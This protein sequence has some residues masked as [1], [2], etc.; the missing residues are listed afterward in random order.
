MATMG[1]EHVAASAPNHATLVGLDGGSAKRTP[2]GGA[3][4]REMGGSIDKVRLSAPH[5]GSAQRGVSGAIT[6]TAAMVAVR[7]EPITS[8]QNVEN[9]RRGSALAAYKAI[10]AFG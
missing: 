9:G 10:Q 5:L 7:P 1:I 3:D 4:S 6:A 8:A 2:K